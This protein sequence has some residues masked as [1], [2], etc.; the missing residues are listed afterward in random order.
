MGQINWFY[1]LTILV[2]AFGSVPKGE[3]A[4]V[5]VP[6]AARRPPVN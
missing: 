2:I 6:K 5:A 4:A 3:L 1:V